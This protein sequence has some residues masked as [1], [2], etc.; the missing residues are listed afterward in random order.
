M[1]RLEETENLNS[2]V[3]AALRLSMDATAHGITWRVVHTV[4]YIGLI[5]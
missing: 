4:D 1:I 5:F 3:N 2:I